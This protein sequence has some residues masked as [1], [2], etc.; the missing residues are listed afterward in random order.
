MD[1]RPR[2]GYTGGGMTRPIDR[3][4]IVGAGAWGTALAM[5]ARRAGREVMMWAFE[6]EVAAAINDDHENPLYLPGRPLDA[7]IGASASLAD[8]AAADAVLLVTPAQRLR[9]VGEALRPHLASDVPVVVCAKGVERGS[10]A[11]MSEVV[12]AVLPD[13]PLAVLSGPTFAAEVA[14][15]LPTAATL[16]CADA[17]LGADLVAA[18]GGPSFRLYQSSDII[19]AEIGGAV[20]NVVA[21][22]CGI[23]TGRGLGEN[24]RAALI[25]RGLAEMSRLGRALG[26]APL[27]LMGLCGLGDLVLTC[28]SMQSRNTSLGVALGKGEAL[29][30]ILAGRHS[31]AEGVESAAAVTALAARLG[32]DMPIC[33][34]VDAV[35]HHGADVEGEIHALLSRAP[36]A[37]S[38]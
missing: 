14:R 7:A 15:G 22:A 26:A 30:D 27:T 17:D 18:L 3:I 23:A 19:G 5:V 37:E 12:A 20:K 13:A 35:L 21:I 34:A 33:A 1:S 6:P 32:I 29:A 38:D 4:G 25:T 28:A 11:L 2:G 16:A 24:A 36:R 31:V 9:A 10:G 8:A